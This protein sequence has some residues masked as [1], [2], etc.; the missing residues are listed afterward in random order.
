MIAR[1]RTY[2]LI[3]TRALPQCSATCITHRTLAHAGSQSAQVGTR[4]F[5]SKT[6]NGTNYKGF[7]NPDFSYV[8]SPVT[9][10]HLN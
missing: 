6:N 3:T 4:R 9:A 1:S 8:F 2:R 10:S 5:S 7:T